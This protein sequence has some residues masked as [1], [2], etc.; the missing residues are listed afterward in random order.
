LFCNKE[1]TDE[2]VVIQRLEELGYPRLGATIY[3][4]EPSYDYLINMSIF[5]LTKKRKKLLEEEYFALIKD[6]EAYQQITIE[7]MWLA[8][9]DSLEAAYRKWIIDMR[10][11]EEAELKKVQKMR[12]NVTN[13]KRRRGQAKSK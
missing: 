13:P 2:D 8:E 5:S 7:S 9:L 10:Q 3:S 11:L 1:A 12:D 4:P 6:C